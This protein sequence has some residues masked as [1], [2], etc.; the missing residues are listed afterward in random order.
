[1]T[2]IMSETTKITG[3]NEFNINC[4]SNNLSQNYCVPNLKKFIYCLLTD[5]YYL[6]KIHKSTRLYR[7]Y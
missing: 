2:D 6:L 1:M 3:A 5:Q 4:A 7:I